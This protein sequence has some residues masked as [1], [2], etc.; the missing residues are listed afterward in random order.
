MG[1]VTSRDLGVRDLRIAGTALVA[2]AALWPALPVHPGIVCPLR[3]IT[4]IP[5]PLCGM[6]TSV[7]DTIHL[8]LSSAIAANFAGPLLVAFALWLVVVRP[9]SLRVPPLAVGLLL[10]SMWVFELHRFA[11]I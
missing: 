5:C 4:G 3:A 2:A 8:D 1:A 11:V 6:T 9:R 7:V 10:G